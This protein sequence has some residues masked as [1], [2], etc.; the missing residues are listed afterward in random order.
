MTGLNA[1]KALLTAGALA[2]MAGGA[3]A[4]TINQTVYEGSGNDGNDCA[5]VF[6]KPFESCVDP[7]YS[8]PIIAMVEFAWKKSED[9][10]GV[11]GPLSA[12]WSINS[13]FAS[14]LSSM[15][16]FTF[17]D[18][19]GRS[20]TWT[21][22]QCTSCPSITSF[23]AK[24]GNGFTHY[25]SDPQTALLTGSWSIDKGLSHLSFYDTD[26]SPVPAPAA[27]FLLAGALGGLAALRRRRRAV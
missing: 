9:D 12:I 6:G 20:G 16:T 19:E 2:V 14:V 25:W 17:D 10:E 27:G 22:A 21:Y 1:L 11:Y 15:F 26:P 24:G 4:A 18:E 13:A 8:S 23:V 5:G 3:C 7:V